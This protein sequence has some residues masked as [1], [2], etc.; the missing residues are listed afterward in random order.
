MKWQGS[1]N[2]PI[3]L[4]VHFTL[5]PCSQCD[6]WTRSTSNTWELYRNAENW[7][8]LQAY[9][10]RICIFFKKK[11]LFYWVVSA[12]PLAM[13]QVDERAFNYL[14][15]IGSL[16]PLEFK[17]HEGQDIR[18]S[19]W[20]TAIF[21]VSWAVL[22]RG[23]CSIHI[24]WKSEQIK[25]WILP[26]MWPWKSYFNYLILIIFFTCKVKILIPIL[27]SFM[28]VRHKKQMQSCQYLFSNMK[29]TLHGD[30][31]LFCFGVS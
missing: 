8:P 12:D 5:R 31:Y 3:S 28:R 11:D 16:T 26:T 4:T 30:V 1:S 14:L 25:G 24:F 17:F 23:K 7:P 9:W 19:C 2:V 29:I 10:I 15:L 21:P 6:S 18:M 20:P 22:G 13:T 27:I